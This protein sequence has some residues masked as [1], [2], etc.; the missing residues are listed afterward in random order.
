M[1]PSTED[2]QELLD[3]IDENIEE[4]VFPRKVE[5]LKEN[6]DERRDAMLESYSKF[7]TDHAKFVVD[8]KTAALFRFVHD[9]VQRSMPTLM[10]Q[11]QKLLEM[12]EEEFNKLNQR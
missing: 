9:M 4:E 1:K 10:A 3:L 11:A 7:H 8:M 6:M 5:D 12:D 2:Y